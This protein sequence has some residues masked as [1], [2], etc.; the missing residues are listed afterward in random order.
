MSVPSNSGEEED[1]SCTN[2]YCSIPSD[3]RSMVP[4]HGTL[5]ACLCA[6]ACAGILPDYIQGPCLRTSWLSTTILCSKDSPWWACH[7][8][9]S[10]P[11]GSWPS[12]LAFG[13]A[14]W[15]LHPVP[16]S[17]TSGLTT[18][19]S[20]FPFGCLSAWNDTHL[21]QRTHLLREVLT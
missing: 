11:F 2:R 5:T 19:C 7:S 1:P 16:V 8:L 6:K 3:K 4:I 17:A 15:L 14:S 13:L 12:L 20:S 21:S 18:S 9:P 10:L